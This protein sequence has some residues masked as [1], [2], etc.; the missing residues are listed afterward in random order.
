MKKPPKAVVPAS[1]KP[2]PGKLRPPAS[3]GVVKEE[4]LQPAKAAADPVQ[5]ERDEQLAWIEKVWADAAGVSDGKLAQLI[6]NQMNALEV[7]GLAENRVDRLMNA[8]MALR[9]MKPAN[10]TEALLA[11]QMFGVHNAAVLFLRRAT[12][13]GQTF[14]GA[15]ANV[16]RATRLLRLFNEQLAAMAK[17]KGKTGQQKVTVEHVHVHSGG[18]AVVGVVEGSPESEERK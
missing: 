6:V 3:P 7:W 1:P 2:V 5:R 14:E 12:L 10:V 9:E 17:L 4:S 15:D 18:Q 16:G 8:A 13:E 11:V